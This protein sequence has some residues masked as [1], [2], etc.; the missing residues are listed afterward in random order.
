MK[1]VERSPATAPFYAWAPPDRSIRVFLNLSLIDGFLAW[2]EESS[3]GG[4]EV[5]GIL[6]GSVEH[7]DEAPVV[8]IESFEPVGIEHRRGPTYTLTEKEKERLG[9][10]ILSAE[11]RTRLTAVGLVRSH[12]R[13]GLYLDIADAALFRRYFPGAGV[14]LLLRAG[15]APVGGFFWE[16]GDLQK[17]APYAQFP[18]NRELLE[19]SAAPLVTSVRREAPR[20]G[21]VRRALPSGA[22]REARAPGRRGELVRWSASFGLAALLFLAFSLWRESR[23]TPPAK[24]SRVALGL[25][26]A[27]Q[28][29]HLRLTWDPHSALIAQA[30]GGALWIDDGIQHT[31]RDLSRQDLLKGAAIYD[32]ISP[33]V[34]FA[35]E[36]RDGAL[37]SRESIR[38]IQSDARPAEVK[39]RLA[40]SGTEAA[41]E[42]PR[43]SAAVTSAEARVR[44]SE[45]R[46]I[47]AR[48]FTPPEWERAEMLRSSD[49]ALAAPAAIRLP[50][51]VAP[52][53]ANSGAGALPPP[54]AALEIV[55]YQAAE[56][57][58][59][60]GAGAGS[61]F[62]AARALR[63]ARPELPR[64][65]AETLSG[66]QRIELRAEVDR[67]GAV[68]DVEPLTRGANPWL[69]GAA[70]T[71]LR[72]WRFEPALSKGRAVTS[73]VVVTFSF[74]GRAGDESR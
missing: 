21:P 25:N 50:P 17:Q 60:S 6:L 32:P 36:V 11:R 73:H 26:L 14:F 71:A 46:H 34:N 1:G 38:S 53:L 54:P 16:A 55:G 20:L 43:P 74:H 40:V 10:E 51:P 61:D 3:A 64:F 28:G 15:P 22:K 63:T 56:A 65:V 23:A 33:D 8:R 27:R 31:R 41:S 13:R 62:V 19:R 18:L 48:A 4:E 24:A 37:T 44:R 5:G 52:L 42:P 47:V 66:D 45:G 39:P 7:G 49:V 68:T 35:L 12:I 2:L 72:R 69:I 9:G 30:S 57:K 59:R 58:F 29:D 67:T 70:D